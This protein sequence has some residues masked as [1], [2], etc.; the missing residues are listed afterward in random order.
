M[1][2]WDGYSVQAGATTAQGARLEERT[3]LESLKTL[4]V[5]AEA[6]QAAA[7][8]ELEAATEASQAASQKTKEL[9]LKVREGR[10]EL[11][12]T[13]NALATAEREVQANSKQLGALSEAL[14]RTNAAHEEAKE[15]ADAAVGALQELT[16]LEGLM[17]ALEAAQS[18]ATKARTEAAQ[19]EANLKSFENEVRLRKERIAA[20]AAEEDLWRKRVANA[21]TQIETLGTRKSETTKDL[22]AL[23]K[24][25]AEIEERRS[26]ADGRDRR[27]GAR[28]FKGG[29]RTSRSRNC[30]AGAREGRAGRPGELILGS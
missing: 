16:A 9:R 11:D 18:D 29:G 13:R 5:E 12:Q 17:A 20:I 7:E 28:P 19:A 27:G 2:R 21:D 4:R 15:Q 26:Q 23:A 24:L 14:S 1:W 22:E 30:L 8:N 6:N 10:A 3:R 25:P